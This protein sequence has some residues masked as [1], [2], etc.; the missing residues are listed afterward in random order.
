MFRSWTKKSGILGH[1]NVEYPHKFGRGSF[2]Y[3]GMVAKKDIKHRESIVAVPFNMMISVKNLSKELKDL[4][5][6]CPSLFS[7]K[8]T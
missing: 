8:E 7:A 4:M 2:K 6:E 1:D 5:S 3:T